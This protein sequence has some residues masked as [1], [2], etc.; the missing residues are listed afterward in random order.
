MGLITTTSIIAFIVQ[1]MPSMNKPK[2]RTFRAVMYIL[3]GLSA[4]IPAFYI[5]AK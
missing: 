5:M 1:M 3:L 4:G 2:W